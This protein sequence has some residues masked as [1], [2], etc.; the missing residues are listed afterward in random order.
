VLAEVAGNS[1]TDR[2]SMGGANAMKFAYMP[3]THG[4]PYDQPLPD[5]ERCAK[6]C[7]H[8]VQEAVTAEG[9]GYDGVFV[10]ERHA[11]TE[12]MW[13]QPLLALLAMSMK[14]E[15]IKLGTYVLQPAYY[16]PAH[17]AEMT[18]LVDQASRGRLILGIGSG[19]HPGYFQHLGEPF[20]KRLGRFLEAQRFLSRAWTGHRFDWNG[21]Y[22][23]MKNVLVNPRP[24]Q[25]P[26]PPIWHAATAERPLRRAGQKADGLALLSFYTPIRELRQAADLYREEAT[27]AGRK[28]VV[29][30]L[31]D[32]FVGGSYEE[33]KK[34]FGPLWVDEVRYYIRWG[35]LP[36]TEEIPDLDHAT[37]ENLEKYMILGDAKASAAA[38]DR[39]RTGMNLG[40]DDWIIFRSRI[41]QGPDFPLVL[42]SIERFGR[43]VIPLVHR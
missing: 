3:D 21:R 1:V 31:L 23:Q 26:G 19:Y 35:M 41:P 39:F 13:P 28:P 16:N 29:A 6:F 27:K 34:T 38:V 15:R 2:G 7:E 8:L 24:Y 9:A 20:D 4:G 33:A 37:Y 32:G 5:R 43:Q 30:I 25:E 36:P 14:T 10:P 17:L 11:R 12:T 22:W 18:A 42:E 40:D